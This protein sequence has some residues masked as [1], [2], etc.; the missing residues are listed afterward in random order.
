M[1]KSN[2]QILTN[3]QRELFSKL[4]KSV[5]DKEEVFTLMELEGFLFGLGIT[6][7]VIS[8]N[9]WLPVIF[10]GKMPEFEGI[11]QAGLLIKNLMDAYIAYSNASH[12]GKLKYPFPEINDENISGRLLDEI[13]DWAYGLILALRLRPEIWHLDYIGNIE[14]APEDISKFLEQINAPSIDLSTFARYTFVSLPN[15]VNELSNY[16]RKLWRKRVEEINKGI[17]D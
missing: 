13:R 3:K 2:N 10:D 12:E 8:I 11:E 17:F 6:P 4:L 1:K 5:G 16:G 9:E 14:E 15:A 7:D